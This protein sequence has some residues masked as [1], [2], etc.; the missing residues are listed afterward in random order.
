MTGG[1]C[2]VLRLSPLIWLVSSTSRHL[3][4]FHSREPWL[5]LWDPVPHSAVSLG[6]DLLQDF[7]TQHLSQIAVSQGIMNITPCLIL[8]NMSD[9][10]QA[11]AS[12]LGHAGA[13]LCCVIVSSILFT[14][15]AL[16]RLH[17]INYNLFLFSTLVICFF[18]FLLSWYS[19]RCDKMVPLLCWWGVPYFFRHQGAPDCKEQP[20]W[21]V[22]VGV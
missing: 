3:L 22:Y 9:T 21:M 8:I 7:S 18:E 17:F 6:T 15:V 11:A 5:Q 1:D 16:D 19:L 12:A 10:H 20:Q 4:L 14:P 2:W 13:F